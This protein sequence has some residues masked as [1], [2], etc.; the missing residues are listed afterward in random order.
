MKYKVG[1]ILKSKVNGRKIEILKVDNKN[2]Y[3][4]YCDLKRG[5]IFD[6]YYEILE[7]CYIEKVKEVQI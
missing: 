2:K 4:Q 5:V 3:Y 7:G 6:M 1:D